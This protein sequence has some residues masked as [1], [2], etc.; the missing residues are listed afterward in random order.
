[1]REACRQLVIWQKQFPEFRQLGV[2]INL[3]ARQFASQNLVEKIDQILE[4]TK[5]D[6][7]QIN[8]EI[9]ESTIMENPELATEIFWELKKEILKCP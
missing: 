3:S 1:M 8:L 5:V 9:T 6:R 4:E 2:S 7:R